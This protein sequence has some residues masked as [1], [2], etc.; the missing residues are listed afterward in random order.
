MIDER[1]R[2]FNPVSVPLI[3][4]AAKAWQ[5]NTREPAL[6]DGPASR[7]KGLAYRSLDRFSTIDLQ[8]CRDWRSF[9]MAAR[10]LP[11]LT[12][13]AFMIDRLRRK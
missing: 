3:G 1:R 5:L 13:V 12:L 6:S 8:K 7:F 10:S 11:D 9:E 4:I 2:S